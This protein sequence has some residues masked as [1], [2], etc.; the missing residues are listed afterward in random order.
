MKKI[1]GFFGGDGQ[2]GTTMAAQSLAELLQQRGQRVLYIM[3]SGKFGDEFLNLEGR[4]SIDDLKAAVRSGRVSG[5]ELFQNLEEIKGLWVLPAVRNPLTARYFPENTYEVLLAGVFDEFDYVVI[6]SGCDAEL[7]L[8][9]SAVNT[10]DYRFFVTTQQS[11]SLRRLVLLMKNVMQPLQKEGS[12]IICKYM[13]DP[14]LLLKRDVL[15][16]CEMEEAFT[17][18]Y[19][20]YGWQAEME[21]K[22]LL[23]YGKFY[24]AMAVLA[25]IFEQEGQKEGLWKKRFL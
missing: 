12:L 18:P 1:I 4:H 20:E 17:V 5:E 25:D 19:V 13:K 8:F 10:A 9:I 16:L 22:S 24:K 23:R 2:V 7:G 6:D 14:G 11:K 21:S 15:T 3:G